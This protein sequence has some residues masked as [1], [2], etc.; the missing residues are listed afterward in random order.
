MPV[1]RYGPLGL[2]KY[3]LRLYVGYLNPIVP[4]KILKGRDQQEGG[5][6]KFVTFE[7]PIRFLTIALHNE[8]SNFFSSLFNTSATRDSEQGNSSMHEEHYAFHIVRLG[9]SSELVHGRNIFFFFHNSQCS[10]LSGP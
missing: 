7:I 1:A 2:R 9:R 10:T 8:T 3:I 4:G 6:Q 5:R